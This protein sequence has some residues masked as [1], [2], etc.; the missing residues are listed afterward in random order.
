[1]TYRRNKDPKQNLRAWKSSPFMCLAIL[2][3]LFFNFSSVSSFTV[4]W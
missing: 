2:I 3:I 4:I 1:M